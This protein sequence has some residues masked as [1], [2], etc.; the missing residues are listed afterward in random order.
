MISIFSLK[1][2][3]FTKVQININYFFLKDLINMI[4]NP[5]LDV[6]F[7]GAF[8]F[9]FNIFLSIFVCNFLLQMGISCLRIIL[10][11][12]C[13]VGKHYQIMIY[14]FFHFGQGLSLPTFKTFF[15]FFNG[16]QHVVQHDD[17]PMYPRQI[18]YSLNL[19]GV[20]YP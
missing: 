19:G 17:F 20:V 1:K 3:L 4:S 10:Q 13:L 7:V 18:V 6:T 15:F 5:W 16:V 9:H 11:L 14:L 8:N 2:Y 12:F